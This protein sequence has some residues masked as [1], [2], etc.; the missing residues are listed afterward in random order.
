[1]NKLKRI[2]LLAPVLLF[3]ACDIKPITDEQES[4]NSGEASYSYASDS[5][6]FP[7][8]DIAPK[9]IIFENPLRFKINENGETDYAPIADPFVMH[10]DDGYFYLVCSNTY[11]HS[12]TEGRK[13][14]YGAIF[15]SPDLDNW[16][17]VSSVFEDADNPFAWYECADEGIRI[18]V[19]APNLTKVGKHY[20]YYY[21]LTAGQLHNPGIGYAYSLNPYG[22]WT[23][24][25]KLFTSNEIGVYNSSDQDIFID[26]DGQIYIIWGSGDGIW[27]C[28]LAEDGMSLKGGLE[29]AKQNKKWIAGWANEL[30]NNMHNYE[31]A[32]VIKRNNRYYLF[33]STG[34]WDGGAN[35]G[36][37]TLV[38]ASNSIYGPYFDSLNRDMK[39][40]YQ[41]D[42][43]LLPDKDYVSGVGHSCVYRDDKGDDWIFY[44]GYDQ[45]GRCEENNK[46]I[47]FVDK[48]IYNSETGMPYVLDYTPSY[49]EQ[50]GPY[51]E[52][53]AYEN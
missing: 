11:V 37:H 44:H 51:V 36:Y 8:V 32:N 34:G 46:R 41:G 20:I 47:L 10:A 42:D 43:V 35:A 13:F 2:I 21:T 30:G 18:Q 15:R 38:C 53:C 19:N 23:Q 5:F 17:Y 9:Q 29:Y 12:L 45:I 4:S 24:G 6:E 52:R 25:G 28:E 26:D 7:D 33:L 50:F 49:G 22:P 3:V 27:V 31:A 40:A 48:L 39:S 16:V 14:D 1:M